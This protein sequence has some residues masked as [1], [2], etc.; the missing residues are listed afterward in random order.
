MH[1]PVDDERDQQEKSESEMDEN[2]PEIGSVFTG[3]AGPPGREID[4][5][6]VDAVQNQQ[7]EER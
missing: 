5:D 1:R 4:R 2:G 3:V 6:E 7:A